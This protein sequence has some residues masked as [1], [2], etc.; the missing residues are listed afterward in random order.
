MAKHWTLLSSQV[1]APYYSLKGGSAT[2]AWSVTS[3]GSGT[4]LSSSNA[5]F[6]FSYSPCV[7]ISDGTSNCC[8]HWL[9]ISI[10]LHQRGPRQDLDWTGQ[11]RTE[12]IGSYKPSTRSSKKVGPTL[13]VRMRYTHSHTQSKELFIAMSVRTENGFGCGLELG[14]SLRRMWIL[15]AFTTKL[16]QC[17][18]CPCV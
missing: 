9:S 7:F 18:R 16:F 8:H 13:F 2:L 3:S 15:V 1:V 6:S 11:D 10:N 17:F 5:L 12:Q 14:L 4:E